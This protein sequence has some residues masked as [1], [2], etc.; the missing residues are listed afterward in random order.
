MLPFPL[1]SPFPVFSQHNIAF[2]QSSSSSPSLPR[3]SAATRPGFTFASSIAAAVHRRRLRA[4]HAH[5]KPMASRLGA[6]NPTMAS[7]PSINQSSKAQGGAA[8]AMNNGNVVK[9]YV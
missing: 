8:R 6:M 1:K 9:R 5:P 4:F 7:T 3:L 2:R